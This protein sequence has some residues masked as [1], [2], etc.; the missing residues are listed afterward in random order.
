MA[1]TDL[2]PH[3]GSCLE[4]KLSLWDE[5]KKAIRLKV[6]RWLSPNACLFLLLPLIVAYVPFSSSVCAAITISPTTISRSLQDGIRPVNFLLLL[7]STLSR[8]LLRLKLFSMPIWVTIDYICFIDID[9]LVKR[10]QCL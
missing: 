9:F 5:G 3:L 6:V 1:R 7:S 2:E 8:G 10:L 4:E